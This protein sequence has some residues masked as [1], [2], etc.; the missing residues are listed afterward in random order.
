MMDFRRLLGILLKLFFIF[1]VILSCSKSQSSLSK[2]MNFNETVVNKERATKDI[3]SKVLTVNKKILSKDTYS[4]TLQFHLNHITGKI[5]KN[6]AHN[7]LMSL[8]N[9][10]LFVWKI[11]DGENM[12]KSNKFSTILE[13]NLKSTLQTMYKINVF[14]LEKISSK[15]YKRLIKKMNVQYI[16]SGVFHKFRDGVSLNIEI[17]TTKDSRIVAS[18]NIFIKQSFYQRVVN[19]GYV[20]EDTDDEYF[21]KLKA[22]K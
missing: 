16:L 8:D 9:I 14:N 5:V 19:M 17:M 10:N 15:N 3:H 12:E 6:L 4:N 13:D 20:G 21:M 22:R 18:S 1:S 2:Y 7:S 11:S